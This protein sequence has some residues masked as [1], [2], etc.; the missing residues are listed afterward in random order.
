MNSNNRLHVKL[1]VGRMLTTQAGAPGAKVL[2]QVLTQPLDLSVTELNTSF[3]DLK[4]FQSTEL[5]NV[6][7]ISKSNEKAKIILYDLNG[8][9]AYSRNIFIDEGMNYFSI[10]N[11]EM[12]D[13]VY[14]MRLVGERN[15]ASMK[16]IIN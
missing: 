1:T 5:I 6:R 8:R 9:E 16:I 12:A 2:L 7:L 10:D 13:G 3:L 4:I 14:I 11:S 15:L